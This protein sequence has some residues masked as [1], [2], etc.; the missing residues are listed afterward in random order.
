MSEKVW[1]GRWRAREG[2]GRNNISR[3]DWNQALDSLADLWDNVKSGTHKHAYHAASILDGEAQGSAVL[4]VTIARHSEELWRQSSVGS[5]LGFLPHLRAK[6]IFGAAER[7]FVLDEE[8]LPWMQYL[9]AHDFGKPPFDPNLAYGWL[10]KIEVCEYMRACSRFVAMLEKDQQANGVDEDY[11]VDYFREE[12]IVRLRSICEHIRVTNE[13]E[14]EIL[15]KIST[16]LL[17]WARASTSIEKRQTWVFEF[18]AQYEERLRDVGILSE[19]TETAQLSPFSVSRR[20]EWI[21]GGSEADPSFGGMQ[22]VAW[23]LDL[24]SPA[25]DWRIMA[26]A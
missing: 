8:G 25:H 18:V 3:W 12:G 10:G 26:A 16:I 13:E 6:I 7:S 11:A 17:D 23:E 14:L 5:F 21:V 9:L 2:E 19:E 20:K 1:E 4:R 15:E 24:A 22:I